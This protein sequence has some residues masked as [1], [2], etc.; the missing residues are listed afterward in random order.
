MKS[1]RR[2]P[3]RTT[4]NRIP[5]GYRAGHTP[6]KLSV[7]EDVTIEVRSTHE[8]TSRRSSHRYTG[9]GTLVDFLAKK[10]VTRTSAFH[11]E[12]YG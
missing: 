6:R 11:A 9:F 10:Q 8:P 4:E 3:L 7:L 12:Y 2:S 1:C 5:T